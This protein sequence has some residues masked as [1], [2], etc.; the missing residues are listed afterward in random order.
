MKQKKL[1]V[2]LFW[3]SLGALIFWQGAVRGTAKEALYPF[4]N[5]KAW[6][7]RTVIV[8]LK[9]VVSRVNN[10]ARNAMLER[11]VVRLRMAAQEVEALEAEVARLRTLLDFSPQTPA[12]WQVAPVLSRGGTAV[13]LQTLRLGKGS[14]HGIRKGDPVVVPDGVVGQITDV[15]LHTADVMLLTDPNSLVACEIEAPDAGFGV[16]RGILYGSGATPSADPSL[17]LLYVVDPLRVRYLARDFEPPPRSRVVTSGLG[18]IFPKGLTVGYVL[19]STIEAEGLSREATVMPA[20]D[21]SAIDEV[22]V[23]KRHRAGE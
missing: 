8:R 13:V 12:H 4:E 2:W 14:L 9:A 6:L 1:W 22:F 20:V 7:D 23:L 21:M 5:A 11:D 19:D 17:T 16:L 10:A 18:R 3:L 15:S